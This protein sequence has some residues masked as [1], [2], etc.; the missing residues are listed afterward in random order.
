[1]INK[2]RNSERFQQEYTFYKSEIEKITLPD[3]KQKG[4]ILLNELQNY[5][6]LIDEGHSSRNN[7]NIDPRFL[8]NNILS[9]IEIRREISTLIKD[10]KN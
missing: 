8:K 4:L 10:S 9:L 6:K 7:G 5:C 1:M 2:L 3:A